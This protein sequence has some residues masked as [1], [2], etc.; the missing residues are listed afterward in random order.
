MRTPFILSLVIMLAAFGGWER[1]S[2]QFTIGAPP[3][4]T[5]FCSSTA[6]LDAL[7][8]NHWCEVPD[9]QLND[10]APD[11]LPYGYPFS[12][13][14]SAW[15]GG[16]YDTENEELLVLGGGH[17]D[18]PWDGVWGFSLVD[19]QWHTRK[20]N[21]VEA[22]I[23][24]P[25]PSEV[26]EVF[27][28]GSWSSRHTY[29]GVAWDPTRN[30]MYVSGGSMW[31]LGFGGQKIWKYD[32]TD[33]SNTELHTSVGA[34]SVGYVGSAYI[35][36][37]D[38]LFM[39]AAD[40]TIKKYDVVADTFTEVT[41]SYLGGNNYY[42]TFVWDDD[43]NILVVAGKGYGSGQIDH[44]V[45]NAGATS[46]TVTPIT[47]TGCSAV[48][49]TQ[50]PGGAYDTVSG[51]IYFYLGANET[52]VFSYDVSTQTCTEHAAA[53]GNLVTPTPNE[54]SGSCPS[55]C[56]IYGRWQAVSSHPGVFIFVGS[57]TGNVAFWR[58]P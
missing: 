51:D 29:G 43:D 39:A 1:P 4:Y 23:P 49:A 57:T 35:A 42:R 28:N 5:R 6:D 41:G 3:T 7:P 13:V 53:A 45:F 36:D 20:S 10:L 47:P 26:V 9:S 40:T 15:S 8:A 12:S 17:D 11:P 33:A 46:A 30:N 54:T 27:P 52:R 38:A 31:N 32:P 37:Y 18:G 58:A 24:R 22:D 25:S 50:A 44:V 2:G 21:S 14:M 19:F 48:M 16:A 56:G 55:G 34:P